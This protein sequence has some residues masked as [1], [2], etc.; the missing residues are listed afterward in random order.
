MGADVDKICYGDAS[1]VAEAVEQGYTRI[2]ATTTRERGLSLVGRVE[3]DGEG[4][5]IGYLDWQISQSSALTAGG[6]NLNEENVMSAVDAVEEED[7]SPV[8]YFEKPVFTDIYFQDSKV[9]LTFS[10]TVTNG[11]SLTSSSGW[12]WEIGQNDDVD[13]GSSY[14][15]WTTIRGV[16]V[17]VEDGESQGTQSFTVPVD[18]LEGASFYRI[19]ATRQDDGN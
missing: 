5:E 14:W 10:V 1:S 17:P 9:Y 2:G 11:I 7:D 6:Y 4:G 3:D 8:P 13:P 16:E 19:R 12:T 18:E 15:T